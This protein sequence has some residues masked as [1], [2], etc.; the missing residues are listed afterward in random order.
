MYA[1]RGSPS[2][3]A[4]FNPSDV[5]RASARAAPT[6]LAA[7]VR[8]PKLAP[9]SFAIHCAR[10]AILPNSG[11]WTAALPSQTALLAPE[12]R[13][14]AIDFAASSGSSLRN[15]AGS[16]E[17]FCDATAPAIFARALIHIDGPAITLLATGIK[18][19]SSTA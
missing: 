14:V 17:A 9:V 19:S 4:A 18:R 12:R 11:C 8:N 6:V 10:A 13:L 1:L 2:I 3:A 15:P 16:D 5:G 7:S